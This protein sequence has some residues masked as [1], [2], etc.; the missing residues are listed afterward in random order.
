[1]ALA[2]NIK[3]TIAVL[4]LI[5]SGVAAA[6]IYVGW[7]SSPEP[8]RTEIRKA[9]VED[10]RAAIEL[11]T[12]EFYEDLPVAGEK[13]HNHIF[14]KMA[15]QGNISFD[16]DS[17]HNYFSGDTL[18]VELPEEIIEIKE[19]TEPGAYSVVDEWNDRLFGSNRM[20]TDAENKLKLIAKEN[21]R[22]KLYKDGT[23]RRARAEAVETLTGLLG[24][25]RKQPVKVIDPTLSVT[26]NQ[27]Y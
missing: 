10:L 22:K 27:G 4:V 26:Q 5:L 21:F 11:C 12:I 16:L 8:D 18:I 17:I 1:M 24:N 20:P 7:K 23:V 2:R 14:A 15:V 25:I 13:G 19:S 3:I 6:W 9:R